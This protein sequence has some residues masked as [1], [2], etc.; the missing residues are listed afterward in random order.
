MIVRCRDL[1]RVHRAV[2]GHVAAL[3]GL[4][5]DLVAGEV[6]A[7]LGPS[8]SG[9]STLLRVLAGLEAPTAGS[10]VVLGRDLATL[11][12]RGRER[13]RRDAL[14]L[15][16]QHSE[17]ALPADL[18][19][20]EAVA[21]PLRLR[22][23]AT[24][25]ALARADDLLERVGLRDRAGA[26]PVELSGGE[27]QRAS[28][29]VALAHEPGLLLADEPT[30]ELDRESARAVLALITQSAREADAAVLLVTHD[31]EAA[32]VADRTVR[33]RDGRVA[34]E[35]RDGTRSVVVDASGWLRVPEE[36]LRSARIGD[37]AV[38]RRHVAGVLIEATTGAERPVTPDRGSRLPPAAPGGVHV[39][40][41][42]LRRAFGGHTVLHGVDLDL[43]PG[44]L[45]AVT[46]RSGSGK[47]TL[48]RILA[49]L[50]RPDGGTV[51]LGTSS[52][53]ALDRPGRAALRRETVAVVAQGLSLLPHATLRAQVPGPDS[54]A[55][56]ELLGLRKRAGQ[57]VAR[58]SAGE[59]QRAA[60][61]R[62][63]A[64]RRRVLVVD[65]PSSRL[66]EVNA[67]R[68]GLLLAA[69]AHDLGRTVICATHDALLVE[70]ADVVVT[71]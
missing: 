59:R 18:T 52:L 42:G 40:A 3:Q 24:P 13:L 23:T 50:E 17:L 66:D 70:H 5:V 8:G 37:R 11:G 45:T 60:L 10:A 64:S 49:G 44:T 71:R 29:C 38:L 61:A 27:R 32:A 51:E 28:V 54:E 43:A 22:G 53:L 2:E 1:F 68:V 35:S 39:K 63:L 67:T 57:L 58:L 47:S 15:V 16:D 31:P 69:A 33:L 7:V 56:L 25:R 41:R 65:E 21:L 20:R 55:W 62:A 34:D 30:G 9:K 26:L 48:L 36:L 19:A 6:L 4:D 14:G 46:G 12:A